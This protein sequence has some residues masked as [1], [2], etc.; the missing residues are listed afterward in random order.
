MKNKV[1]S[2]KPIRPNRIG[3]CHDPNPR[4]M[5]SNAEAVTKKHLTYAKS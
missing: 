3:L 4:S 5:T 2:T 1:I